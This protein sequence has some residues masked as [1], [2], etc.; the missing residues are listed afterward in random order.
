MSHQHLTASYL[1]LTNSWHSVCNK[2][3]I[4]STFK[5]LFEQ[6]WGLFSSREIILPANAKTKVYF[7]L[8]PCDRYSMTV[9]N[10]T[11]GWN[12]LFTSEGLGWHMVG[13]KLRRGNF[14]IQVFSHIALQ[15]PRMPCVYWTTGSYQCFIWCTCNSDRIKHLRRRVLTRHQH[16]L[17]CFLQLMSSSQLP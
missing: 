5:K 6:I 11:N 4:F 3:K 15:A 7:K 13:T 10:L 14:L 17:R 12:E 9:F 16:C 8:C 2:Q 1:P